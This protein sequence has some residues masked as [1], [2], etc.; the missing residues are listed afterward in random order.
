MLFLLWCLAFG[1]GALDLSF[2]GDGKVSTPIG[3]TVDEAT[4]C[5]LRQNGSI[6]LGGYAH[7]GTD[8]DFAMVGYLSNGSLD[9]SF[10]TG[11]KVVLDMGGTDK[12]YAGFIQGDGKIVLVGESNAGGDIDMAIAR[13]DSDGTPDMSFDTDAFTL[14]DLGQ[15]ELAQGVA[16]QIDG[17]IVVGGYTSNGINWN[18]VLMRLNL[19]GSLDECFDTDGVVTASLG[20]NSLAQAIHLWNGKILAVGQRGSDVLIARY[21]SNGQLDLAFDMDGYATTAVAAISIG[22][23]IAIQHDGRLV[24]AATAY[25]ATQYFSAI[26]YLANGALDTTFGVAGIAAVPI[27]T[28]DDARAIALQRDGKILLAGS[29]FA[30]SFYDMALVRLNTNGSLDTSFD[31]DGIVVQDFLSTHDVASAVRV[32]PDGKILAAG[33]IYLAGNSD[34]AMA[35]YC[36]LTAMTPQRGNA[37]GLTPLILGGSAN[38]SSMG[39][40]LQWENLTSGFM[41]PLNQ[42]PITVDPILTQTSTFRMTVTDPVTMASS[43]VMVPILVHDSLIYDWNGDGCNSVADIQNAAVFWR[44]NYMNDPNGDGWMD[45]RDYLYINTDQT[46]CP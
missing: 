13:F 23:A 6:V 17:K 19:D 15:S 25:G 42:N 16:G 39:D 33:H 2:D 46:V 9:M 35:R 43:S 20:A 4:V 10:G 22:K 36:S 12:A 27:Q 18:M 14:Q 40:T 11:G 28:T 3:A 29:T 32:Q 5:L 34:F 21:T 7:N 24:V 1:D 41:Y 26:R 30:G 44:Q 37:Q 45:I 38:C 31:M 8:F